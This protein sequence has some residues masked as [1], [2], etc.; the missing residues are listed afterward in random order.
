MQDK[1]CITCVWRGYHGICIKPVMMRD[2]KGNYQMVDC[3][4][5]KGGDYAKI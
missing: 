5:D 3:P 4:K 2:H 1:E